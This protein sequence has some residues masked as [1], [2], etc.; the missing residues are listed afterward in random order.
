M[1]VIPVNKLI[2]WIITSIHY[3]LYH[4]TDDNDKETL[5]NAIIDY[6][7]REKEKL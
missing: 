4:K 7:E 2:E 1:K 5:L 6:C 3:Y